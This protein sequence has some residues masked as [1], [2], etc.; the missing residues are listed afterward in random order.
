M[1]GELQTGIN[2]NSRFS[3][4]FALPEYEILE[5]VL[6]QVLRQHGRS[7][8]LWVADPVRDIKR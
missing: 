6:G 4:S 1:S 3:G 2:S 5:I 7:D 8:V